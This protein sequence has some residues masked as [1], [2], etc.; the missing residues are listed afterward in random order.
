MRTPLGKNSD[1][2]LQGEVPLLQ[3]E[4]HPYPQPGECSSR[5][6]RSAPPRWDPFPQLNPQPKRSSRQPAPLR[7]RTNSRPAGSGQ[8]GSHATPRER[9]TARRLHRPLDDNFLLDVCGFHI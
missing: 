8:A 4:R 9:S 6:G 2:P 5:L 3:A 7:T 1:G